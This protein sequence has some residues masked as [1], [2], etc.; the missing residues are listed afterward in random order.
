MPENQVILTVGIGMVLANLATIIFTSDYRSTPVE[1]ASKTWYLSDLWKSFT[2]R[3]FT[4]IPL[5]SLFLLALMITAALWF[6]LDENRHSE[7]RSA[8]L[9]R[10]VRLHCSWASMSTEC[11]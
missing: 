3:A 1:Y 5:D 4:F 9:P 10:T 6:F 8:R 7:S 2:D 11:A